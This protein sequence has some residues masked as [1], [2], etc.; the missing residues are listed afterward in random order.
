MRTQIGTSH[1]GKYTY[2]LD[3][4]RYVYQWNEIKQEWIG[5][6]CSHAS[7]PLFKSIQRTEGREIA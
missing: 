2:W 4:D 5:W 6:L 1:D 7:W 3:K